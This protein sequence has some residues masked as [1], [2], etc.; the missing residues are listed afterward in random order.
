[1]FVKT[2]ILI[3]VIG[4]ACGLPTTTKPPPPPLPTLTVPYGDDYITDTQRSI[5]REGTTTT[6][7]SR[8]KFD[9]HRPFNKEGTTT[10]PTTTPW[11]CDTK[12]PIYKK[13]SN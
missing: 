9:T 2:I 10:P 1:M 3:C 11:L 4:F 12:P 13:K 5:D 7:T 8:P 6:T